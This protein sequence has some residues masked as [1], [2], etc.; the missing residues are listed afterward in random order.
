MIP[1]SEIDASKLGAT[2]F[3]E[4]VERRSL[5]WKPGWD[6]AMT[7]TAMRFEDKHLEFVLSSGTGGLNFDISTLFVLLIILFQLR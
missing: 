2:V 1:E 5:Q 7:T 3:Q 4:I 6:G